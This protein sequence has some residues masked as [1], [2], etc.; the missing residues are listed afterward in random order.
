MSTV[1]IEIGS[2]PHT[3]PA[4]QPQG[5]KTISEELAL[6]VRHTET[7][8]VKS[9]A[10]P[11]F[12]K[13]PGLVFELMAQVFV[14]RPQLI[15]MAAQKSEKPSFWHFFEQLLALKSLHET[16]SK[17]AQK[18][19]GKKPFKPSRATKDFLR[20][21]ELINPGNEIERLGALYLLDS[22]L[23][24]GREV[25]AAVPALKTF[26]WAAEDL[27][28]E[29]AYLEQIFTEFSSISSERILAGAR[30]GAQY[31]IELFRDGL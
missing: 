10:H 11:I 15:R 20:Y 26:P 31:L 29:L 13:K 22:V 4:D 30:H 21:W 14:P 27:E 6:L 18:A 19:I 9:L 17:A 28:K 2:T 23:R 25:E 5:P 16:K 1:Q 3:V 8:L 12:K 24:A 7:E